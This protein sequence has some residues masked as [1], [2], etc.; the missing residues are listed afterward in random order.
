MVTQ[1]AAL[2]WGD[3]V[4]RFRDPLGHPWWAFQKLDVD[5]GDI[6]KRAQDPQFHQAMEYVQSSLVD[7]IPSE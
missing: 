4:S 6:E 5:A 3:I 2:A 7:E 1:P